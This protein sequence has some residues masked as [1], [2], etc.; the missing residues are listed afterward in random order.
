VRQAELTGS[1]AE[2]RHR[3]ALPDDGRVVIRPGAHDRTEETSLE[4]ICGKTIT[5]AVSDAVDRAGTVLVDTTVRE[6]DPA[7]VLVDAAKGANLLIVGAGPGGFIGVLLGSVSQ[8]CAH[9]AP[10]PIVIVRGPS[11][12]TGA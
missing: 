12:Q 3:L 5:E 4:G 10:C 2:A 9:H 7:R 8:H 11:T 6:D 1:R